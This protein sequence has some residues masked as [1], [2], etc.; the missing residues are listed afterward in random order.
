MA[1]FLTSIHE[2]ELVDYSLPIFSN[3]LTIVSAYNYTV[4]GATSNRDLLDTYLSFDWSYFVS[5]ISMFILFV[6]SWNFCSYISRRLI[7]RKSISRRLIN[8]R[9]ITEEVIGKRL[10]SESAVWIILR[11]L[12]D[13]DLFPINFKKMSKVSKITF[14]F[15]PICISIFFFLLIRCFM[16]NMISTDLVIIAQPKVIRSYEDI[17]NGEN[18]SA[19]FLDGMG[20]EDFFKDAKDG[21][22]EH[23]IWQRRKTLESLSLLRI[24][25]LVQPTIEQKIC[26][27]VRH[28]IAVVLVYHGLSIAS[29]HDNSVRGLITMDPSG[30]SFT[31]AFMLNTHAH[32]ILRKFIHDQ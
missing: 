6:I 17:L 16:F 25:E 32:P 5:I 19:I 29:N 26:A 14:S 10:T 12:L 2:S 15:L 8:R 23:A 13:Q 27:I 21:T 24:R 20:E 18:T 1:T 28:W 22:V 11:A 30:K 7:R 4:D 31:G 9:I 3:Y